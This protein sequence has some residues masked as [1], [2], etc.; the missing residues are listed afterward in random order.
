[1]RNE[2]RLLVYLII[3]LYITLTGAFISIVNIENSSDEKA[4]SAT[5]IHKPLALSDATRQGKAKHY[6]KP[7][8]PLATT[9][10]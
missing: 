8:V 2:I 6:S 3:L 7:I 4:K 1:M 9:V 10:I 5:V